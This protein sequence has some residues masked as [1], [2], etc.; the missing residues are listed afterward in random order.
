[1]FPVNGLGRKK[2]QHHKQ[3]K[4]TAGRGYPYPDYLAPSDLVE[5]VIRCGVGSLQTSKTTICA[6]K[7][8]WRCKGQGVGQEVRK[9]LLAFTPKLVYIPRLLHINQQPIKYILQT[10]PFSLVHVHLN[11]RVSIAR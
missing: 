4:K 11:E 9:G 1:M 6:R 8:T 10:T 5:I 3:M 2:T 7:V